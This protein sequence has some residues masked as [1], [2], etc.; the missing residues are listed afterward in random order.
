MVTDYE[1]AWIELQQYVA[2]K[3]Q[4][5]RD[6]LLQEMAKLGAAHRV[7][8]GETS[9]LLRL[10]SI[11]VGRVAAAM[12]TVPDTGERLEAGFGSDPDVARPAHHGR[13]GHDGR[14]R[15]AAGSR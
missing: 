6:G 7:S 1:A 14:A 15:E 2:S 10:Y 11:E 13:G 9:R 4:H 5:G 8:A 12:A 3:P